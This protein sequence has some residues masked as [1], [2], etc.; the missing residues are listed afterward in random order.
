M[1]QSSPFTTDLQVAPSLVQR[2][3]L[4][5]EAA[6]TAVA[7]DVQE[8]VSYFRALTTPDPSWQDLWR[9]QHEATTRLITSATR[10][11]LSPAGHFLLVKARSSRGRRPLRWHVVHVYSGAHLPH[12]VTPQLQN[13]RFYD[14]D[15]AGLDLSDQAVLDYADA[16]ER[17]PGIDGKPVDWDDTFPGTVV[18]VSAWR[19]PVLSTWR[20]TQ[21]PDDAS[22]VA[23]SGR[24]LHTAAV[25]HALAANPMRDA[26]TATVNDVIHTIM[27]DQL[28]RVWGRDVHVLVE[29]LRNLLAELNRGHTRR[30]RDQRTT[31]QR[32]EDAATTKTVVL[33]ALHAISGD[34]KPAVTLLRDRAEKIRRSGVM[35]RDS[36]RVLDLERLVLL[37]AELFSPSRTE[38]QLLRDV[39]P[40]D[41]IASVTLDFWRH[42]K[43]VLDQVLQVTGPIQML[44]L[45]VFNGTESFCV[46]VNARGTGAAHLV[47]ESQPTVSITIRPLD[48]GGHRWLPPVAAHHW[49]ILHWSTARTV[50]PDMVRAASLRA[51]HVFDQHVDELSPPIHGHHPQSAS[52]AT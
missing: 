45:G 49:A 37:I 34:P 1:S 36:D 21:L 3:L 10:V 31:E 23:D 38:M 40:G 18:N 50:D 27:A 11:E 30:R 25:L 24:D 29:A 20:G 46:P 12:L 52:P 44:S 26:A 15:H 6:S 4:A 28:P 51:V 39:V 13:H 16:L 47:V 14:P 5:D 7:R 41:V 43:V 32:R 35:R 42:S 33:A 19:D 17:A 8:A 22:D 2:R 48:G 9:T